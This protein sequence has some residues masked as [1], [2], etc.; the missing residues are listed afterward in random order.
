M[1][2]GTNFVSDH[3]TSGMMK[4]RLILWVLLAMVLSF[5]ACVD[6]ELIDPEPDGDARDVVT[7]A[8]NCVET[9]MKI[10]FTVNITKH[11]SDP[12]RLLLENFALIGMGEHA[13]GVLSGPNISLPVQL[14]VQ[15][16]E[17][18]GSGTLINADRI[19]WQYTVTAGGD[20]RSYNAVF[21]R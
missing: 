5:T 16:F 6:D 20:Q 9:E 8:W 4:S 14:P 12:D 18:S 15:G 17:L 19:D 11:P 1:I 10:A 2:H 13:E 3:E 7:G 21:T